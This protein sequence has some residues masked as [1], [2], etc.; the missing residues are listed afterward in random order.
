MKRII[1]LSLVLSLSLYIFLSCS[2][3]DE[4]IFSPVISDIPNV[5]PICNEF[6]EYSNSFNTYKSINDFWGRCKK[7]LCPFDPNEYCINS[8]WEQCLYPLQWRWSWNWPR[9]S[10][11]PP[12]CNPEWGVK[13]YPHILYGKNPHSIGSVS[14]TTFLPYRLDSIIA[15]NINYSANVTLNT[16]Y[17]NSY[18]L[19]V[20]SW[21]TNSRNP[22]PSNIE[23]EIMVWEKRSDDVWPCGSYPIQ[24]G[25]YL[26]G[27]NYNL[28]RCVIN[29]GGIN[30]MCYSFLPTSNINISNRSI[31]Y[32]LF[33]QY[34]INN[35]GLNSFLYLSNISFGNEVTE[36]SGET[37][38]NPY[39]IFQTNKTIFPQGLIAYYPFNRNGFD[40]SGN[41]NHGILTNGPYFVSD[42]FNHP[43]SALYFDGINDYVNIDAHANLIP[44][45]NS[46]FSVSTWVKWDVSPPDNQVIVGYGGN[47]SPGYGF[48]LG[49]ERANKLDFQIYSN[50]QWYTAASGMTPN[51]SNWYHIVGIFDHSKLYIYI[52]NQLRAQSNLT[53]NMASASTLRIG[54]ES[55]SSGNGWYFLKGIID[56]I[57]IYNMALTLNEIN[58]L[59]HEGGW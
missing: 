15:I 55:Y 56:D 7:D 22:S 30:W 11:P 28:Y 4:S 41:G 29:S 39:T 1:I 27:N 2:K 45:G 31:N 21:I 44:T 5:K 52:N 49:Y 32:Y 57:R 50:S 33:L 19:A 12:W 13:S 20:D 59:Y 40:E 16:G 26:D 54:C 38:V 24:T 36:G 47:V 14:T 8:N 17:N 6:Y 37:Y 3:D 42:R 35:Y 25:I 9:T 46:N 58:Q 18:N 48:L 34:L 23:F 10:D 51:A 53:S 43:N